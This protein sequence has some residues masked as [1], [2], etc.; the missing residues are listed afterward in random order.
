MLVKCKEYMFPFCAVI[1]SASLILACTNKQPDVVAVKKDTISCMNVPSRFGPSAASVD[2]IPVGNDSGT[3]GMVLIPGGEFMMGGDNAQASPDEL[4]KH[5]V[6][7]GKFLMDATE[8][9]NAQFKKFV[10]ETKHVTIAERKPDWEELKKTLPPGTAKPDE[11][12]LVASS[13]VFK[14]TKGPVDLNNYRE[15][16]SWIKGA[17]WQ[18]PQGPES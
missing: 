8:V 13:L 10:D 5:K 15:W 9:T 1:L 14:P 18:H 4:P 2:S 12:L 7:V 17:D 16:W 6:R 11:S 3:A